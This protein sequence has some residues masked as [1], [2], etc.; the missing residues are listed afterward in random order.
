M[1]GFVTLDEVG[2]EEDSDH[3]KLRKSGLAMK[4]AGKTDDSLAEIKVD[5]IEEP[6]QESETLENGTKPEDNAKAEA[7]EASDPT[8]AQDAEKNA[9]ENTDPQDE[10]EPKSVQEKPLIPDE[11]RIGP[12]QPNVP[13]GKA[14]S[15]LLRYVSVHRSSISHSICLLFLATRCL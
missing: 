7:V 3:Q 8:T 13:V 6:E 15:F 1:E 11:F 2:D 4:A 9:L 12:Y 14:G 5:K 10:Q